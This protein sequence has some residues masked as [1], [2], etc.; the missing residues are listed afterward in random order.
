MLKLLLAALLLLP[1]AA[2]A[3]A[4]RTVT[5]TT[6][7]QELAIAG[8]CAVL[9]APNAAK[10]SHLRQQY[11]E[12]NYNASADDNHTFTEK[13]RAF[14]QAK[15]IR[16]VETTATHLRFTTSGGASTVL[17]MSSPAYSWGLLLF[18]GQAA[19]QEANL[20]DPAADVQTIM[21]K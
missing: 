2:S 7:G 16:V 13:A 5:T 9:Y 1:L 21:K 10:I 18:N 15:G 20:A 11:G 17:D 12:S 14:L 19:P 3:Q 8:P 4:R 6:G